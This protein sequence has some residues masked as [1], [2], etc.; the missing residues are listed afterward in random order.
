MSSQVKNAAVILLAV[1]AVAA[2]GLVA[3]Q[4]IERDVLSPSKGR[5]LPQSLPPGG[6]IK[7]PAPGSGPT[8]ETPAVEIFGTITDAETGQP[9]VAD[10]QACP[11]AKR[12]TCNV[13]IDDVR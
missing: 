2:W 3:R 5:R 12:R 10:V 13:H 1:V 6:T 9:V 8:E 4:E 11:R 7:L